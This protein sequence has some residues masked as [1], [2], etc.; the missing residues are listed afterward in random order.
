[1]TATAAA[2]DMWPD[3]AATAGRAQLP[4]AP[5]GRRFCDVAL[6]MRDGDG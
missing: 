6:E 3:A 4:A 1:V 2:A 5:R